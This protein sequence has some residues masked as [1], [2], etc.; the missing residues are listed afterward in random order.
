MAS[1]V[2]WP[3]LSQSLPS[4]LCLSL[5]LSLCLS[6]SLS[7][8]I[9]FCLYFCPCLDSLPCFSRSSRVIFYVFCATNVQ[10]GRL[11][12]HNLENYSH[13]SAI[14]IFHIHHSLAFPCAH[15]TARATEG[16][17]P[18]Y[19]CAAD[20]INCPLAFAV[21]FI[22]ERA[23]SWTALNS[24][25]GNC[26]KIKKNKILKQRGEI[27]VYP[28]QLTIYLPPPCSTLPPLLLSTWLG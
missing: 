21:S 8:S 14:H 10:W 17:S 3:S 6:L 13:L 7:V 28:L 4:S 18:R 20:K 11:L 25:R 19:F 9:S 2:F 23:T 15:S 16:R 5:G 22:G 26:P 27:N 12:G 1:C 24:C